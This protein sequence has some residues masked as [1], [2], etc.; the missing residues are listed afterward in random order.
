MWR[1]GKSK[2]VIAAAVIALATP[3]VATWEGKENEAYLDTI[4]KP[5]VWTVCYGETD[6]AV[7]YKGARYTDSEC[8][9]MLRKSVAKYYARIETCMTRDDI[10]VS[11]QASLLELAYNAGTTGVCTSTAMRKANAGDYRG[12]CAELDKWV[13]SGG[14]TIKGLV[15]RRNASQDMCQRDL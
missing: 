14:K 2:S 9:D 7:A 6:P 10:P 5:P 12:A 15:N 11:V 13:K 4:P 3:F 1:I 8:V